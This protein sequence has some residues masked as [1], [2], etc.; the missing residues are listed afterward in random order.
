MITTDVASRLREARVAARLTQGEVGRRAGL[1]QSAVSRYE[2]G[3]KIPSLPVLERLFEATGLDLALT[4]TPSRSRATATASPF[5]GPVGR[6]VHPR[7]AELR[8]FFAREGFGHPQVF[9][10]V[11]RG[12]DRV[13]SDLDVVVD[14]PDGL[15]LFG[16]AA[17]A[18]RA[19]DIAGVVV[20]V[21]PR[22]GL[23]PEVAEAVSRDGVAL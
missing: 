9:G 20:D 8:S 7:R 5:G 18:R 15:G 22:D 13:D 6:I 10:S 3:S 14:L 2:G 4:L 23:T 19:S 1:P 16:L 17:A 11:S 21:V 12:D